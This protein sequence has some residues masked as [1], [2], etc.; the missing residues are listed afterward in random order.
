MSSR[1]LLIIAHGSRSA[2]W[3]HAIETFCSDIA[4]PA[5]A[6]KRIDKVRWCYLEHAQPTIKM[7]LEHY[8]HDSDTEIIALPLFLSISSHVGTDIPNEIETVAQFVE[9]REGMVTYECNG[10]PIILLDPPPTLDVLS[11]NIKRRIR[12][13]D[14]S[15]K[16]SGLLVVYYGSSKYQRQWNH[17]AFNVQSRLLEYFPH[18]QVNWG[19]G[20]EA[21]DFAAEPLA[22]ILKEMLKIVQPVI[23]EPALV[24]VGIVQNKIIPEAI[25]QVDAGKDIIYS[26]DAILPDSE[27]EQYVLN[28]VHECIQRKKP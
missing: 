5:Y 14:V 24:A 6:D 8:C 22:D 10:I 27:L 9:R 25:G 21:V 12:R 19:Y 11:N 13:L 7:A 4:A 18:T 20:G 2:A 17:L 23:I 3:N 1:V 15:M 26:G 16:E 28:Y